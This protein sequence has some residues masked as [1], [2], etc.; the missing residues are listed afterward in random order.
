VI[1]GGEGFYAIIKKISRR[2][3]KGSG[4]NGMKAPELGSKPNSLDPAKDRQTAA[5]HFD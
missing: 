5:G 2:I 1:E 4:G 3:R